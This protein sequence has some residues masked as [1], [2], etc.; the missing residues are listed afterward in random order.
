MLSLRYEQRTVLVR[1]WSTLENALAACPGARVVS[2]RDVDPTR[3]VIELSLEG[4]N[5]KWVLLAS[6]AADC[7]VQWCASTLEGKFVVA[8]GS[9]LALIDKDFSD[10]TELE[11]ASSLEDVRIIS[12]SVI[13]VT[14]CEVAAFA[15]NGEAIWR[16]STNQLVDWA[17]G[18]DQLF[19]REDDDLES[20][21]NLRD[22]IRH[23]P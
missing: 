20:K 19:I 22:G 10:V 9:M 11:F 16:T 13:A 7:V 15:P 3:T 6:L 12:R 8:Y 2:P 23:K 5:P 14:E 17:W 1:E 18:N 21:L 4:Y